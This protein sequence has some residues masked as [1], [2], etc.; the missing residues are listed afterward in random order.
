MENDVRARFSEFMVK[1]LSSS[2]ARAEWRAELENGYKMVLGQKLGTFVDEAAL[3]R[4]I[5]SATARDVWKKVISPTFVAGRKDVFPIVKADDSALSTYVP[6]DARKA[7]DEL[8]GLP[9][10]VHE[11]LVHEVMRQEVVEEIM[12]DVLTD[13]LEEFNDKVNPFF[14]DWGLPGLIKK[15]VPIG[16]GAVLKSLDT[17]R[18]EYDKRLKPE[19]QKFLQGFSRR[20]LDKTAKVVIARSDDPKSVALRR[21]IAK[22]L[23]EQKVSELVEKVDE[24][25]WALMEKAG[26]SIAQETAQTKRVK[27]SRD[28]LV[29]AFMTKHSGHTVAEIL[30][31]YGIQPA[32]DFDAIAEATFPA[33]ATIA[34]SSVATSYVSGIVAEFMASENRTAPPSTP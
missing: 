30:E 31:H 14:A 26:L 22:W 33:L 7:I 28:E 29:R 6:E 16:G 3:L 9:G 1:R 32:P 13:A 20:A 18:G 11:K 2:R 5:E 15:F 34:T 12:R 4:A 25:K 21:A 8:L 17:V 24:A 10:F 19:I 27:D 23:W